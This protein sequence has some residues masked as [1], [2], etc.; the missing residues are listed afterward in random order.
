MGEPS[1]TAEVRSSK[2]LWFGMFASPVF[3]SLHLLIGYAVSEAACMT[4]LLGFHI[5]GIN[6]LLVFLVAITLLAMGGIAWNGWWSYRSWRHYA[7]QNPEEKFPL[8]AYDRDEF[9]ALSGLLLSGIFF[10]LLSINMY[11][12]L[13]LR[14]CV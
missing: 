12:F 6:A 7:R 13:V 8:Q 5:L 3:W 4:N 14:L 9:L 11:P 2:T 10:F 1:A